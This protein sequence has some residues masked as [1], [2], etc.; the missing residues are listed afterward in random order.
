VH[1]V[2]GI[3]TLCDT[4]GENSCWL[5]L[6]SGVN[7]SMQ[8]VEYRILGFLPLSNLDLERARSCAAHDVNSSAHTKRRASIEN[9]RANRWV[10]R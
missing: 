10:A 7:A 4:R 5:N 2:D 1:V 8:D 9:G 6:A 3:A